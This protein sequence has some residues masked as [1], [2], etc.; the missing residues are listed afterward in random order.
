MNV[1]ALDPSLPSQYF[2]NSTIQNF[3]DHLMVEQWNKSITYEKY[4]NHCQPKQCTYT[5]KTKNTAIDIVT[6]LFGLV[7]GLVT[8][9]QFI[10][11][12]LVK[13]IAWII[14]KRRRRIIPQISTIRT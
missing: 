6:I 5:Y 10:V 4:Y 14:A 1:T 7:G 12:R 3:F 8:I 11:P 13:L 9:L 2:V